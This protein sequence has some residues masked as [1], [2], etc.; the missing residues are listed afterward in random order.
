MPT[1][2]PQVQTKAALPIRS[3]SITGSW[4]SFGDRRHDFKIRKPP[5]E[6]VA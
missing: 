2:N 1:L 6:R 3:S 5:A 4:T